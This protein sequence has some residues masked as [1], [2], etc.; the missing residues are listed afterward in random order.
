MRQKVWMCVWVAEGFG[1]GLIAGQS[2]MTA[3]ARLSREGQGERARGGCSWLWVGRGR[4]EGGGRGQEACVRGGGGGAAAIRAATDRPHHPN[5]PNRPTAK[6]TTH[7]E[8]VASARPPLASS[9]SPVQPPWCS[10]SPHCQCTRLRSPGGQGGGGKRERRGR[11]MEEGRGGFKRNG[12]EWCVVVAR[13]S[14]GLPKKGPAGSWEQC[15][16]PRPAQPTLT[17]A[18]ETSPA[19]LPGGLPDPPGYGAPLLQPPPLLHQPAW[20]CDNQQR[21]YTA[22]MRL[23]VG[24]V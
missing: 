21:H 18:L 12:R 20:H 5:S 10:S 15:A 4:G 1:G 22:A 2:V 13:T 7:F 3:R 23:R 6:P 19:A 14:R 9:T 11:A 24:L 17:V 8:M 16:L